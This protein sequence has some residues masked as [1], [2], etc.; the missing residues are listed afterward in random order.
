MKIKGN[1]LLAFYETG[2]PDGQWYWDHELFY[3]KPDPTVTYDTD[4][5]GPLMWDGNDYREP[6]DLVSLIRKWR[7][8]RGCDI[9]TCFVP[10]DG[11]DAFKDYCE[12]NGIAFYYSGGSVK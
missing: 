11:V 8:T 5:L 3:D 12:Q 9:L 1:E 4:E 6:L 7:K 10:K 2:W